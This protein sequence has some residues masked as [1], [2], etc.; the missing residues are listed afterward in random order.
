VKRLPRHKLYD[1]AENMFIEQGFTCKAI[2]ELLSISEITLSKWRS[3]YDWDKKREEFL[4]SPYQLR[5]LLQTEL[6][7]MAKGEKSNIDADGLLKIQK[8][9]AAFEKA[10]LSIPVIISVFK[11]LDNWMID[12]DPEK[13][14]EFTAWHKKYLIHVAQLKSE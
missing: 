14:V 2:S 3:D 1:D 7:K 12:Q 9:Y 5:R 4:T 13:A 11:E 8:V 10:S 6:A